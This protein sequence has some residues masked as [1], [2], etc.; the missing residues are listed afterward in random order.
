MTFEDLP[1]LGASSA[2]PAVICGEPFEWFP[3]LH[4]GFTGVPLRCGLGAGH[5]NDHLAIFG[6]DAHPG[7]AC[8]VEVRWSQ[9]PRNT[10]Y[11]GPNDRKET[12]P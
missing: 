7:S 12:A 11:A 1:E 5:V 10:N 3:P 2:R 6:S 9:P 4:D 8:T